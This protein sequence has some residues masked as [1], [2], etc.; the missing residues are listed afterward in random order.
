[1]IQGPHMYFYLEFSSDILKLEIF[2]RSIS[3][4][5]L[6]G[7]FFNGCCVLWRCTQLLSAVAIADADAGKRLGVASSYTLSVNCV[8][9]VPQWVWSCVHVGCP[10]R[11]PPGVRPT[12]ELVRALS[13]PYLGCCHYRRRFVV[14][15][16]HPF[17]FRIGRSKL[18]RLLSGP[19]EGTES[20]SAE[21]DVCV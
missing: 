4:S 16:G 9:E 10:R 12:Q 20:E 19:S 17:H 7:R 11:S 3:I 15:L 14:V 5:I 18:L 21:L 2:R 13:C 8:I 1:L 6:A